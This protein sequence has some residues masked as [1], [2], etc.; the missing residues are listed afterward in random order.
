MNSFSALSSERNVLAQFIVPVIGCG[1]SLLIGFHLVNLDEN[2]MSSLMRMVGVG[3]FLVGA[4]SPRMGLYLLVILCGY[5]D[6][7]KRLLLF[8]GDVTSSD[9]V[10]VLSVAPLTM[11]GIM[12]GVIIYIALRRIQL[13]WLDW[14]LIVLIVL[15]EV[16]FFLVK[17]RDGGGLMSALVNAANT[18]VYLP[19]VVLVGV[20]L[21]S[22]EKLLAF[23]RY[24]LM[25]FAPVAL[26]GIWQSI[27]GLADFEYQYL[28]SGLTQTVGNLDDVRP[29]PFSTLNSPH[30]FSVAMAIWFLIALM[31]NYKSLREA[32]C[33][34]S[35]SWV[36]RF[37]PL[38]FF[39]ASIISLGRTG[40]CI[41]F[42]GL[43]GMVAFR[44]GTRTVLFYS[45]F[46]I[47]FLLLIF[48]ARFVYEHL[49]D[50]Q[51]F[52]DTDSVFGQQALRLG[53]YSERLYGYMNVFNNPDLIT[54]FGN[55]DLAYGNG[56]VQR[57]QE[58]VHDALGQLLVGYGLVGLA[59]GL[60][61]AILFLF[62][63]HRYVLRLSSYRSQAFST[64]LLSAIIGVLG[65][66]MLTGSPL[67]IF[68]I[69]FIFWFLCGA[70]LHLV[71]KREVGDEAEIDALR[72][73]KFSPL[74]PR[75]SSAITRAD[76]RA[77][78]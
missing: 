49:N 40:W 53:T 55:S 63:A 27:F 26:Y 74:F 17:L 24:A 56:A 25:V 62:H 16:G 78:T 13:Q 8:F 52:V 31:Q 33:G 22:P 39:T 15:A 47:L 11:A 37:L 77:R 18:G 23:L 34:L 2:R 1:L 30:S 14:R 73:R 38:L 60:T 4:V 64:L 42:L 3:G 66:A 32:N 21:P 50:V 70:L 54:W 41:W 20:L 44:N 46:V 12:T 35:V 5:L 51:Y 9:L 75:N 19:L 61:C 36:R 72:A 57:Q 6:F 29:R 59:I 7:T 67:Y 68:P 48:N 28:I 65:S 45:S 69:N 71:R 76:F 43:I 58:I 10:T